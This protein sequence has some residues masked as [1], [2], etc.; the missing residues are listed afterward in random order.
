MTSTS[1]APAAAARSRITSSSPGFS[2]PT[3]TAHA[4][5]STPHSSRI[6]RTAT[7]V[8][9]PPEYAS[10]TRL[11]TMTSP[12]FLLLGDLRSESGEAGELGGDDRPADEFIADDQHGV[13]A[14]DR[15]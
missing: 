4:M 11:A 6:H 8:S 9:S 3:S 12:S 10:T 7:E 1:T 13:V 5:T 14:G 2:C 15:A